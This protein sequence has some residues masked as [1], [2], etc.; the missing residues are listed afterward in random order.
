MFER[1]KISPK[2][3]SGVKKSKSKVD[4]GLRKNEAPP[5]PPKP[6]VPLLPPKPKVDSGLN[7]K[8]PSPPLTKKSCSERKKT[9]SIYVDISIQ[10]IQ[11]SIFLITFSIITHHIVNTEFN[12]QRSNLQN[13]VL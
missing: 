2:I 1:K 5:L 3:K 13:F 9:I 4:L 6:K 8:A 7:R 10:L 12:Y 11:L